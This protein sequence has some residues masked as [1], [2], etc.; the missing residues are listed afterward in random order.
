MDPAEVLERVRERRPLVHCLT[1]TVTVGRVADALAA[2]GALPVMASAPEEAADM[3]LHAQ[4]LVLNLGTPTRDRWEACRAAGQRAR[5]RGLPVVLDPVGCGATTWRTRQARA[6]VH[7]VPPDV[8]RGNVPEVA[9]LAG[10]D[11]AGVALRGVTA[12]ETRDDRDA[13]A[14][15]AREASGALGGAV[16]VVTSRA[17]TV[18]ADSRRVAVERTAGDLAAHE[19]TAGAWSA[20]DPAAAER[21]AGELAAR[22]RMPAVGTARAA[23]A[24]A[25]TPELLLARVVGAGDVLTAVVAACCAV[26]EAPADRFLAVQGGVVVFNMAARRAARAA[27]GPGSFWPHLLDALDGLRP[28]D[29]RTP[30]ALVGSARG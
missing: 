11:A 25:G 16:V 23:M 6:L 12:E 3:V 29:P 30:P 4:A 9:A 8:V 26:V 1:N 13:Q 22:E 21:A 18:V 15:L 28:A 10:L 19:V 5:E 7:A 2:L 27:T 24:G 20:D 17:A 14:W